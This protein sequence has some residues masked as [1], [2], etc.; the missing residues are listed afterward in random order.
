MNYYE[1]RQ[2]S[3]KE[4]LEVALGKPVDPDGFPSVEDFDPWEDVISGIHGSYAQESDLLFISA[5]EAIRDGRTFE[6]IQ[7][8]GF[9]GEFALYVLSGH[10]YT[11]YGTSPRGGWW[12]VGG[13]DVLNRLIEK[14]KEYERAMWG[15]E[16]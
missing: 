3:L 14:W 12:D 7:E 8:R 2:K 11:Q 9:S 10:G 1:R 4:K 16:Q 6:F 5:L 13:V 15:G